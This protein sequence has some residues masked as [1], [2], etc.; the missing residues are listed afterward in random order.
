MGYRTCYYRF[1]TVGYAS[2]AMVDAYK[3][4]RDYLDAAIELVRP[5]RTTAEIA[6]V[7]PKAQE[8]GFPN[9]EAC[10]ALQY[11]YGVGLAIWQKPVIRRLGSF[12]HPHA[13]EHGI[14][15]EPEACWSDTQGWRAGR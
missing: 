12:A 6:A 15:I 2:H 5:G 7:W 8:Y 11:G 13:L 9:E 10:F 1:F 4:C 14:G 3:Q